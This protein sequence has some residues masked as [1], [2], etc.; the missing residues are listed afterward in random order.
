[1]AICTKL[2]LVVLFLYSATQSKAQPLDSLYQQYYSISDKADTSLLRK[3]SE[4]LYKIIKRETHQN[5]EKALEL[6]DTLSFLYLK[7]NDIEKRDRT[8]YHDKGFLYAINENHIEALKLYQEYAKV[9]RRKDNGYF[10][11]DLGNLYYTLRLY[12]FAN[13]YYREAEEIFEAEKQYR[14]LTTVYGNY[15]LVAKRQGQIDTAFYYLRK[16]LDVQQH[17]VKD[18][19]QIAHTYILIGRLYSENKKDEEAA[20]SNFRQAL[21]LLSMVASEQNFYYQQFIYLMPEAYWRMGKSLATLGNRDSSLIC[22]EQT[23]KWADIIQ[24]KSVSIQ[25]NLGAADIYTTLEEY[26]KALAFLHKT[27]QLAIENK[28]YSRQSLCCK[29]FKTV[30]A[31]KQDYPNALRYADK[32]SVIDD[33]LRRQ[34]AKLLTINDQVL[35]LERN[36]TIKEQQQTIA[37]QQQLRQRLFVIISLVSSV[38][39][40]FLVFWWQLRK[41]NKI[42]SRYTNELETANHV[43]ERVLLVIGHDLRS[44]FHVIMGKSMQVLGL[45]RQNEPW[46]S[47]SQSEQLHAATKKAYMMM[48]GLMQWGTL[49]QEKHEPII[50]PVDVK[51]LINNVV[52][53]LQPLLDTNRVAVSNLV[54][55]CEVLSDA[56]LLQIVLRNLLT[57]AIRHSPDHAV[58]IINAHTKDNRLVVLVEDQGKGIALDILPHIFAPRTGTH[59]AQRGSGLGLGLVAELCKLLNIGICAFNKINGTGAVFE[60]SMALSA[61]PNV[62]VEMAETPINEAPQALFS[63]SDADMQLLLP[64]LPDLQQCEVF[65]ASKIFAVLHKVEP[66]AV[67]PALKNWLSGLKTAVREGDE[68]KYKALLLMVNG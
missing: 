46:Q 24:Q 32:A 1:M 65:E 16:T 64:L 67:T 43:K 25:A 61:A 11:I 41:K 38:L 40:L 58:I 14:G 54:L 68:D 44:L 21:K 2:L 4:L 50:A 23:L 57:N 47:V 22:A 17:L 30:Y 29:L 20:V 26:D 33:S 13:R 8:R 15:A 52:E 19:F 36:N 53:S 7:L 12:D 37:T 59:I 55:D 39:L 63:L 51:T 27:E 34:E 48:D 31:Q 49:Q 56:E 6:I 62:A 28:D 42:I 5:Q 9:F 66:L 18:T 45:L 35:Q 60:L 3:K 10:L